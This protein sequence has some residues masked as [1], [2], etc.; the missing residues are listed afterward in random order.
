MF[1]CA[2]MAKLWLAASDTYEGLCNFSALE[3]GLSYTQVATGAT[4]T[5]L[6]RSDG[7]AV[8][9]GV[10]G[11]SWP[12]CTIPAIDVFFSCWEKTIVEPAL[13]PLLLILVLLTV[14]TIFKKMGRF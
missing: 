2:A 10:D 14:C 8:V 11:H 7:Q 9:C 6:L 1:S 13:N 12:Q 4:H 5:V 3:R